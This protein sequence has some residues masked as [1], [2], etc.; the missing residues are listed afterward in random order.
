MI[1]LPHLGIFALGSIFGSATFEIILFIV[2][3]ACSRAKHMFGARL[4]EPS[5]R[6]R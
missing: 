5:C 4:E 6:P 2:R 1:T 3:E